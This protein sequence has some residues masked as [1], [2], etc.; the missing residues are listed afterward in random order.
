MQLKSKYDKGLCFLLCAIDIF[1]KYI[2]VL[3][4]KDKKRIRIINTFEKVL[5]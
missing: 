4:L 3:S 5:D 1:S 2:W